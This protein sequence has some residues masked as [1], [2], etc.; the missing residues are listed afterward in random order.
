M[1]GAGA[2]GRPDA[3]RAGRWGRRSRGCPARRTIRRWRR[4]C[5]ARG[6]EGDR[7]DGVL[8]RNLLRFLRESLP[9]AYGV[10][11]TRPGS[12]ARLAWKASSARSSGNDGP[13]RLASSSSPERDE[14]DQPRQRHRRILGAVDRPRQ[15]LLAVRELER[16]ELELLAAGRQADDDGGAAAAR[17]AEREL[18]RRGRADRVEG[19]VDALGIELLHRLAQVVGRAR[20]R[21]AERRAPA[22]GAPRPGRRRGSRPRRRSARPGRRTGRRRRRRSRAR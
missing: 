9:A 3:A 7:L 10:T 12:P 16:V 2:A 13:T 14:V 11:S 18:R 19:V 8:S 5:A 22:R 1:P 15:R 17:P 20:A 6:W 4:R 21:R